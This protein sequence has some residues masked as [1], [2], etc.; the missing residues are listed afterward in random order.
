MLPFMP[1]QRHLEA[2]KPNKDSTQWYYIVNLRKQEMFALDDKGREYWLPHDTIRFTPYL[3][4]KLST[5][6]QAA[7]QIGS[8]TVLPYFWVVQA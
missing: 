5:A 1:P 6:K 7:N 2:M 3:F 8:V 4:N